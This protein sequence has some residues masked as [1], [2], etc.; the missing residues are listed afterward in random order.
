MTVEQVE[1]KSKRS[2]SS[3]VCTTCGTTRGDRILFND[4]TEGSERR[5]ANFANRHNE[6]FPKH[7]ILFTIYRFISQL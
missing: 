4:L 2:G 7:Q 5:G 6:S 1:V 3:V